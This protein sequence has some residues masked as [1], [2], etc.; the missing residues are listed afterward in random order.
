CARGLEYDYSGSGSYYY[1]GYFDL[2]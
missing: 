2:W 1:E